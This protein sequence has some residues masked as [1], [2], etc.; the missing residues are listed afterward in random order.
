VRS[1]RAGFAVGLRR[2]LALTW[3][4]G[5]L[6]P[7]PTRVRLVR[8]DDLLALDLF[9]YN[10]TLDTSGAR[11]LVRANPARP[12]F[13]VAQFQG[14]SLGE[15]TFFDTGS[16]A[17]SE[18][19]PPLPGRLVRARLAGPSRLAFRMPVTEASVDYT[20][21][22]LLEACRTW[23][24]NLDA[25]AAPLPPDFS[26]DLPVK[27]RP[28]IFDSGHVATKA[29]ADVFAQSGVQTLKSELIGVLP[30][31]SERAVLR[32]AERVTRIVV[33]HV[34]REVRNG[35]LDGEAIDAFAAEQ[36]KAVADALGIRR[37]EHRDTVRLLVDVATGA[38]LAKALAYPKAVVSITDLAHIPGFISFFLKPHKPA[39]TSTAIEVPYRLYQSP[40]EPAGWRHALRPVTRNGRTE[41]WHTRLTPKIA[42]K[43]DEKAA[44]RPML[45]ALWSPDYKVATA[46][47]PF[48]MSLKPVDRSD[49]VRVTS[50]YDEVAFKPDVVPATTEPYVPKPVTANRL[51]LSALGAWLDSEG[52][53]NRAPVDYL[54]TG[55]PVQI[56]LAAWRHFA[57]M[58]RDYYVRIVRRGF[59]FPLGHRAALLE[60]TERRFEDIPAGQGRGAYLRTFTIE[61]LRERIKSYPGPN[62]RFDGRDFPFHTVEILTKVTPKLLE[63]AATPDQRLV[64]LHP[65]PAG[66]PQSAAFWPMYD[67]GDGSHLDVRFKMRAVDR[68][69]REVSFSLP[70]VFVSERINAPSFISKVISS[71]AKAPSSRRTAD[72]NGQLVELAPQIVDGDS[73]GDTVKPVN[74]LTFAGAGPTLPLAPNRP[75]FYP[76]AH[77]LKVF[78]PALAYTAKI[79][80]DIGVQYADVYKNNGFSHPNV[81]QVFL[82]TTGAGLEVKFGGGAAASDS[83]GALVAPN[84]TVSALSRT[85]G[86][87]GGNAD[88]FAGGQFNPADF[89]PSA[90]LFGTIDLKDLIAPV[91]LG[92]IGAAVPKLTKVDFPDRIEIS[93]R[94][95][96]DDVASPLPILKTGAG[97]T[98]VLDVTAKTIAYVRVDDP[99]NPVGN[100]VGPGIDPGLKNPEVIVDASLTH[101]KLNLFGCIILWF[102]KLHFKVKAGEKPDVDPKLHDTD[103][104]VF[105]GPLEFVN[106]LS[107][108]LPSNGFSDPPMLEVSAAGIKAGYSLALPT[109]A[110]GIFSLQ[111]MA[112]GAL[113]RL[114]FDGDPVSVRFNF[115][116]RQKPFLL[117]V[118]LFGGGGFFAISL[119]NS[120]V[121]EVEAAFEFGAFA[122]VNLGVASGSVYVK[123]GI[124]YHWG[125]DV[126]ELEG[127]FEMG[128]EM[129]V[130]GIISV[131]IKFHLSLGYYKS[132]GMSE[133]KGQASLVVE[134]EILFFSASV[135]VSV[136][137]RLA[138]S[139]AD[140]LLVDFIPDQ[141]T[142]NAYAKAFA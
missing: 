52:F 65:L 6:R 35:T 75:Q 118:S 20:V 90:K 108:I 42:G 110:V 15:Q 13:L 49:I 84:M 142:W 114:P 127:Y 72:L 95:K 76:A 5:L 8:A 2:E 56:D 45:R 82:K 101:F 124:Y 3:L 64:D 27:G 57:A 119:D 47:D 12:A 11:K 134:I 92:A 113:L 139:P 43:L 103:P 33:P 37:A 133:V 29:A 98:S 44:E 87:V 63:P 91:A 17:T 78:W 19:P 14:Q 70:L 39:A 69:G 93:F 10:L 67:P 121:R 73:E 36:T 115:S 50:G 40:I 1:S 138:G 137:K 74:K 106:A 97:G 80:G 59:K 125:Q 21:D 85:H 38:E 100:F 128:G 112:I 41:L 107:K 4:D 86:P 51:M 136:E 25:L 58:G 71:Y 104:V 123:A 66:L 34:L 89:F 116:E 62:Q 31:G 61:V 16:S 141:A 60:I 88:T 109:L 22:A 131:S 111:N 53:W 140:P 132:S 81:G 94:F 55:E 126:V 79:A 30:G 23:P 26:D 46:Q 99:A 122:A 7:R 102:D 120:G 18:M 105:G 48:R 129:S 24:M 117:T 32:A 96:R 83:I 135:T 28:F 9:L 130:L 77:E 54:P 68:G